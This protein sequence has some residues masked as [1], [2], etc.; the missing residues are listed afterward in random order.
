MTHPRAGARAA[1][2]KMLDGADRVHA[3]RHVRLSARPHRRHR[4]ASAA[5]RVDEAGFDAAMDAQRE[6][7]RAASH[8]QDRRARSSTAA[9][10]TRVPRLRD[11]V[12]R[13]ARVVALYKDGA[14]GRALVDRRAAASSC[15][16]ARRSTPSRAARSATA[17]SSP[18][19]ARASRC[20]R[21]SDT[22]KVQPDV[23]GHI[24]EVKTGEL[25]VGDTVA[26][27][28]DHDARGAHHAQPLG[29]APHAQGAARGARR[30]TCSRRARWS[31][32]TRRASTSRTTR[33]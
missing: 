2:R 16:T 13:K 19:A 24:G 17:A 5:S 10:K 26:A 14:H 33:R 9:P 12:A 27:Q 23:F 21:S 15:S 22:Q 11:A 4:A 20:S 29:D 18:R 1:T 8:V 31:T 28:V 7:A 25:R 32:P 30:R 6:R 3:L